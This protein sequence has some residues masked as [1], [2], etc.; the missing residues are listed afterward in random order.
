MSPYQ[1]AVSVLEAGIAQMVG[2][3][4]AEGEAAHVLQVVGHL[5][6]PVVPENI[7]AHLVA[8]ASARAVIGFVYARAKKLVSEAKNCLDITYARQYNGARLSYEG[9]GKRPNVDF[10]KH[11]ALLHSDHITAQHQ[12][13]Q[14]EY[15]RDLLKEIRDAFADRSRQLEQISNNLRFEARLDQE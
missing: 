2:S 12:L 8:T 4:L 5:R 14:C 1:D 3:V 11:H 6:E 13:S 7:N 10:F 9:R 15:N